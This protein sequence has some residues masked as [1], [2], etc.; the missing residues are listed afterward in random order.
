MPG[1]DD[2]GS[3]MLYEDISDTELAELDLEGNGEETIPDAPSYADAAARGTS[4]DRRN[5]SQG[6]RRRSEGRHHFGQFRILSDLERE[7]FHPLNVTPDR[8]CTAYFKVTEH[9][10]SK[11][12]FDSFLRIGIAA[13]AVRCLQRRPTGEV[14]VTFS[15]AEQRDL[16]LQKS[17]LIAR[18]H[19]PTHIDDCDPLIYLTIYDAPYELPDSAIEHRLRPFCKVASRRRGKLNGFSD[20]CN[21]L[22]HYRISLYPG[23]SVPCYLRFGKFQLRFYHNGQTKTCRKCS[24]PDHIARDCENSFCFNCDTIGHTARNCENPMLCCICKSP[25]HK[26]IDCPLSWY[27]RPA[28]VE[29]SEDVSSTNHDAGGPPDPDPESSPRSPQDVNDAT[30][31]AEADDPGPRDS[32]INDVKDGAVSDGEASDGEVNDGAEVNGSTENVEVAATPPT[33]FDAS[34][35]VNSQGLL[36]FPQ[37]PMGSALPERPPTVMPS[38]PDVSQD[39]EMSD[40]EDDENTGTEESTPSSITPIFQEALPLASAIR[41]PRPQRKKIGRRDPAKLSTLDSIPSR[42]ATAPT[43]ISSRRRQPSNSSDVAHSKDSAPD[44][45]APT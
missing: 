32:E 28:R 27:R 19:Y 39:L 43:L 15:N 45:S 8:P 37:L 44:G 1:S 30:G 6:E 29:S 38:T 14:V 4:S 12:I 31:A 18:H 9:F 2:L 13:S 35:Y 34:L 3:Q 25:E 11:Q 41:R 22:R 26:A 24:S 5:Y 10:T 42:K 36:V 20:T 17:P 16:F 7:N 33:P 40:D 23:R 21:G